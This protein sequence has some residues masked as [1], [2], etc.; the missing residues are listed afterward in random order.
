MTAM[1][2][3]FMSDRKK[4]KGIRRSRR[5]GDQKPF[6]FSSPYLLDVLIPFSSCPGLSKEVLQAGE[7]LL[8]PLH[9][10]A[11]RRRVAGLQR[12][13]A[14]VAVLLQR[15]DLVAQRGLS[16]ADRD[17]GGLAV[18]AQDGIL[19]MNVGEEALHLFATFGIA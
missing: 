7:G 2:R 5:F 17:A 1:P 14:L 16:L 18:G 15:A 9:R 3:V 8:G 10:R 11:A 19:E 4:P 6:R 13:E 12:I